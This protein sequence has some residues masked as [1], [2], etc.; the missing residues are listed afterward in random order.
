MR[1]G[2]SCGRASPTARAGVCAPKNIVTPGLPCRDQ[3]LRSS[4]A[5]ERAIEPDP[6]NSGAGTG[7]A[8]PCFYPATCPVSAPIVLLVQDESDSPEVLSRNGLAVGEEVEEFPDRPL[9]IGVMQ[10]KVRLNV[11]DVAT[12]VLF[13]CHESGVG[14]IGNDAVGGSLGHIESDRDISEA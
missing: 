4:P 14:Q 13:F 11:V 10:R 2:R 6:V 12:P 1:D 9:T 3:R 8:G 7:F 5:S